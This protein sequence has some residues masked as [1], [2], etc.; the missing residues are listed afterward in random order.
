[1][2]T[3]FLYISASV[4]TKVIYFFPDKSLFIDFFLFPPGD[5]LKYPKEKR[6]LLCVLQE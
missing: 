4:L 5:L 6:Q 2:F 3:A 1:M